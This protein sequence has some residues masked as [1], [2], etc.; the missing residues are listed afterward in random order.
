MKTSVK[1]KWSQLLRA[2][3]SAR[4]ILCMPTHLN[5]T[6][7]KEFAVI[8][9]KLLLLVDVLVPITIHVRLNLHIRVLL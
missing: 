9:A 2:I 1:Y 7:G 4:S 6:E 8:F 5:A 3:A